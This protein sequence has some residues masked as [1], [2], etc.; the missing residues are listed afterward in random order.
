MP[1]AFI[2]GLRGPTLLQ[3]EREFLAATKPWGVI[4]FARNVESVKQLQR[5]TAGVRDA[6]GEAEAPILIDQEGGRVQ[7]IQ[8]PVAEAMPQGRIYGELYRHNP[9]LGTE[10]ASLGAKLIGL[11]LVE[12]GI[13]VNTLPILDIPVPGSSKVIGNR[14]YGM[15]SDTVSTLGRSVVEGLESVGVRPI[16]KHMPGH[17]RATA[18]SH[19]E[20]PVVT[21]DLEE[22]NQTDFVPFRLLARRIHFGMTAHVVFSA[23]DAEHPATTS[24]GVI[25]K[26]IR[27]RIGFH[28][29]LVT[30]DISM[31]ALSGD[32]P[33]RAKAALSAGC[34][35]VLHCNGDLD[36]MK[37]L[38][39][40]V[41]DVKGAARSRTQLAMKAHAVAELPERRALAERLGLL[42]SRLDM[43]AP[44]DS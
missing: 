20:L 33:E 2:C 41:P 40:I 17:G 3:P 10:A 25:D 26:V 19:E 42:L 27:Q 23:V 12:C 35:L 8:P 21:T 7:R 34:D 22:L 18:D 24:R 29:A 14:A 15:D 28:G 38:A 39:E 9:L 37:A 1:K 44:A 16:M 43:P 5:L 4:L 36:E 31:G 11:A 30:D 32:I 13:N 6:L